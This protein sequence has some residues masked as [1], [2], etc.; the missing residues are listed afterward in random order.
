MH[1]DFLPICEGF[2][3]LHIMYLILPL[4]LQF[5]YVSVRGRRPRNEFSIVIWDMIFQQDEYTITVLDAGDTTGQPIINLVDQIRDT[6]TA[7]YVTTAK[8]G[9]C[10][11]QHL[12][13][14]ESSQAHYFRVYST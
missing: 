10:P 12:R 14:N 8:T 9:Q 13:A 6:T 5:V 1:L 11:I 4:S 3:L 2:T 7:M